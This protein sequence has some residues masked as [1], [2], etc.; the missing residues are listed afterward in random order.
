MESLPTVSFQTYFSLIAVFLNRSHSKKKKLR[1]HSICYQ[2][3]SQTYQPSVTFVTGILLWKWD[4]GIGAT[5]FK[6]IHIKVHEEA[7]ILVRWFWFKSDIKAQ[8]SNGEVKVSGCMRMWVPRKPNEL[9]Q[10][11]WGTEHWIQWKNEALSIKKYEYKIN[12]MFVW[13]VLSNQNRCD[14][15]MHVLNRCCW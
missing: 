8:F 5:L 1:F 9:T 11:K 10:S 3:K 15:W 2:N 6:K 12:G 7:L 4:F 14:K 13:S